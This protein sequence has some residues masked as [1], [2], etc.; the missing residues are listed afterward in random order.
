MDESHQA[1][2]EIL[3]RRMA[4][5][6]TRAIMARARQAAIE[7]PEFRVDL[8][9]KLWEPV[10][11]LESRMRIEWKALEEASVGGGSLDRDLSNADA[12][13]LRAFVAEWLAQMSERLG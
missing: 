4:R 8:A 13:E 2:L 1:V 7:E 5:D 10:H 9:W 3:A 6:I 11:D 12:G